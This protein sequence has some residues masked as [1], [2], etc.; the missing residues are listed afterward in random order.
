MNKEEYYRAMLSRDPRFDG[1]FFACVSTTG[2]YCR[3]ICPAT[4]PKFKNCSF[5]LSAA[6]AEDAGYRP[7]L[8]CRPESA[9]GSPAWSGTG[10]TVARAMRLLSENDLNGQSLEM[11][12][13]R[14]GVG[15][16]HLR[17]LFIEQIG[18]PPK[19]LVQTQRLNIAM[20]LLRE[21]IKKY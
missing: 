2:I 13:G 5:V 9:P 11:L 15:A 21:T 3:P 8:R 16:R 18:A 4:K 7:C 1:K 20:Q 17:R 12:A 6:A 14:L 19:S 10:S